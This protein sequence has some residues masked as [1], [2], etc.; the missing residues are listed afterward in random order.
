MEPPSG[1][2][3]ACVYLVTSSPPL[4]LLFKQLIH[5]PLCMVIQTIQNN[6][7]RNFRLPHIRL[8]VLFKPQ[9]G[10][11][12]WM[13]WGC[14]LYQGLCSNCLNKLRQSLSLFIS[15]FGT[16]PVLAITLRDGVVPHLHL[17]LLSSFSAKLVNRPHR[18][19]KKKQSLSLWCLELW[20]IMQKPVS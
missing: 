3:E 20:S 4:Q 6:I 13:K 8:F 16:L 1:A 2:I 11:K 7:H 19:Q 15:T 18:K 9:I 12:V 5:F 14:I 17:L 10:D